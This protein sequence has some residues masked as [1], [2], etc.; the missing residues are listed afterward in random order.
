KFR[1]YKCPDHAIRAMA[2]VVRVV[3]AAQ[4]IL[5]GR[6]DDNRYEEELHRLIGKLGL[7]GV[8]EFR[9]D[10]TEEE[11]RSLLDSCSA[12]LLP[13]TVEGFGI[14]VLE[15]NARGVPVI[16]S[17]GVPESAVRGGENGLRYPFGRITELSSRIIKVL[18]DEEL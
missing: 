1:R 9:F 14:V 4:L 5:A 16:A 15:A 3:P 17:S 8:A 10:I 13:S 12:L 11:K 6:H 18:T 7:N 2:E